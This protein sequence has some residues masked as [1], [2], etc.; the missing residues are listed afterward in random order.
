M[1]A[2]SPLCCGALFVAVLATV[3]HV[4]FCFVPPE[5]RPIVL[6]RPGSSSRRPTSGAQTN[7]R[8]TRVPI[9]SGVQA[10]IPPR[11]AADTT[12]A[13][14]AG[15]HRRL[16]GMDNKDAQ[17]NAK[18]NRLTAQVTSLVGQVQNLHTQLRV[19]VAQNVRAAARPDLESRIVRLETENQELREFLLHFEQFFNRLMSE[20]PSSYDP[21]LE[22]SQRLSRLHQYLGNAQAELMS[23][24]SRTVISSLDPPSMDGTDEEADDIM[25]STA[26]SDH[27]VVLGLSPEAVGS[28]DRIA[29]GRGSSS[30]GPSRGNAGP[31]AASA[32]GMA[33]DIDETTGGVHLTE[34]QADQL[35]A[36]LAR[37]DEQNAELTIRLR[38][39]E[40]EGDRST[41]P[42]TARGNF[43]SSSNDEITSQLLDKVDLLE[44]VVALQASSFL[45]DTDTTSR[46]SISGVQS[47]G[48]PSFASSS[49]GSR[50]TLRDD[51]IA[52]MKD[53][54][55][56]T[57]SGSSRK[58]A[59]SVARTRSMIG[60]S[61]PQVVTFDHVYVNKGRDFV[62]GNG[63]FV[64]ERAGY[65]FITFTF[66]SYDNFFLGVTLMKNEEVI[67]AIYTDAHDRNVME[68]QSVMVHLERGDALY[69]RLA[70]SDRFGIHSDTKFK[71]V[72]FSGFL[73]YSG[74]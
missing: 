46:L 9:S 37:L 58:S 7:S 6:D 11:G 61:S 70:P 5:E 12:R 41:G 48:S 19:Q 33:R 8:L 40:Q 44:Q 60:S 52:I 26:R 34:Q 21:A 30:R 23:V 43:G 28:G 27:A 42:V 65:Y 13:M 18:F 74:Y 47:R 45:D 67:T 51:D 49:R 17:L 16:S 55:E 36:A 15:I 25:T 20:D 24:G 53:V 35:V 4:T 62:Q 14:M 71:Y 39:L 2:I 64:C 73:V 50:P 3:A 72:T 38:T 69:L 1:M 56:E 66:R 68:S 57:R 59:F 10:P 32:A 31:S 54:L 29:P 22:P 63:S